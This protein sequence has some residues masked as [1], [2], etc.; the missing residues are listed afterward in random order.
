MSDK[1]TTKPKSD[2]TELGALWKKQGQAQKFLSGN[3]DLSAIGIDK[4]IPVVI[5]TNKFKQKDSHPDYRIFLSKPKPQ[6]GAA[7]PAVAAAAE[8]DGG[9]STTDDGIL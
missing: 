8:A 9:G 5:F 6:A 7:E 2:Q 3:L 4:Q 1:P